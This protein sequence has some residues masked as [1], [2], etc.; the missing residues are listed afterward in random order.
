MQDRIDM[1]SHVE[2]VASKN[3]WETPLSPSAKVRLS[4]GACGPAAHHHLQCRRVR[5]VQGRRC[6]SGCSSFLFEE[7]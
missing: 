6:S 4:V 5:A 7:T 3:I 1:R 2:V